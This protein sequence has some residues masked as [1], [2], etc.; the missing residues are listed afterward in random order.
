MSRSLSAPSSSIRVMIV[1]AKGFDYSGLTEVSG[2]AGHWEIRPHPSGV[3]SQHL[4][5]GPES[6]S[7]PTT[8]VR[9]SH[10]SRVSVTQ[11]WPKVKGSSA[12][13]H[14]SQLYLRPYSYSE[15]IPN[16]PSS[17]KEVSV[18]QLYTKYILRMY[19]RLARLSR[20]PGCREP[21][22]ASDNA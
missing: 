16:E 22:A 7:A 21:K 9:P 2:I 12:S 17:V 3:V 10:T 4:R 5:S 14:L 18:T 8:T 19:I 13:S 20:R 11:T 1:L 6:V 15:S